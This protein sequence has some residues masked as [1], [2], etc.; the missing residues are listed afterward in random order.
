MKIIV[1]ERIEHE[2]KAMQR[3][4]EVV[5]HEHD[6]HKVDVRQL[7]RNIHTE[8]HALKHQDTEEGK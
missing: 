6:S 8:L 4:V 1:T 2:G 7:A 3:A 5:V